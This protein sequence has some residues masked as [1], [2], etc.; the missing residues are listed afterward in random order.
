MA[1]APRSLRQVLTGQFLAVGLLPLLAVALLTA[2]VL[3]PLL[4]EQARQRQQELAVAIRDKGPMAEA[5]FN[6]KLKDHPL[7]NTHEFAGFDRIRELEESFLPPE[8]AQKYE[9]T[10]GH[11]PRK[12]AE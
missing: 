8:T 2:V 4:V 5:E 1:Q 9:G 6:R 3:V 11:M 12:A 7:G 10:L